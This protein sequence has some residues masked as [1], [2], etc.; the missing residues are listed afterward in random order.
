MAVRLSNYPPTF[1]TT[2][3]QTNPTT[4]DV[5][6]DTGALASAVYEVRI[7]V[8]S[9]VA[10]TFVVQHRDAANTGNVGDVPVIRS[11]AGQTAEYLYTM[12]LNVS[13]RI[14]VLPEA[15]I[16]GTAEAAVEATRIA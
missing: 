6:A 2:G 7:W 5:L 12:V 13:E 15:N 1:D 10:A 8:G 9:S 4:T 11:A 3:K 14:R 16:T